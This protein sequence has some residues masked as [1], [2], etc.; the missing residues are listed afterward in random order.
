MYVFVMISVCMCVSFLCISIGTSNV[1]MNTCIDKKW[2]DT[3]REKE[4]ERKRG[5][6]VREKIKE[7]VNPF[8]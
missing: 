6:C 3:E 7:S 8:F 2:I 1:F 4:R 5:V